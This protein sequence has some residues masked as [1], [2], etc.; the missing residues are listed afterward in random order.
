M[1]EIVVMIGMVVCLLYVIIFM[2]VVFFF[3]RLIDG[4]IY[5]LIVVGV[6]LI[7]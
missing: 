3:F 5:G 4:I 1:C 6:R 7:I 2:F